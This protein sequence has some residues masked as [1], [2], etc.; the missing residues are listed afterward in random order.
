MWNDEHFLTPSKLRCGMKNDLEKE[1][2]TIKLHSA[3]NQ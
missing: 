2:K 3:E 1:K